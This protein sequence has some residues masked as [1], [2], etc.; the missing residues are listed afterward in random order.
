MYF[1][2]Q[3]QNT[4]SK[5]FVG[6]PIFRATTPPS[7]SQLKSKGRGKLSIHFTAD[8]DTVDTIYRIILSVNQFSVYGA[9]A[10]WCYQ[11]G[12]TEEEGRDA[13]LVDNNILTVVEPEEVELMVS[14]PTQALGNRMQGG[15]LSFQILEKKV[16]LTQLCEKALTTSCDCWELSQNSTECRRRMECS[17]SSIT[18]RCRE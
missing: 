7:R 15:A 4:C 10:N 11:F 14:L 3:E 9:V 18:P 1:S 8:Q 13:I 2:L 6:H 12:L 5:Q 17:Y 16:Q